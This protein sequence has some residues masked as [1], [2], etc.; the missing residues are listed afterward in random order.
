MK[1]IL[2]PIGVIHSPFTKLE[3]MPIQPTGSIG[4]QGTIEIFPEY[5]QALQDLEGFSHLYA[6]Y[7]FHMSKGWKAKVKP[8][9]DD[10][11]RGLFSTRAPKRPNPIGLSVLEIIAIRENC[12]TVNN[13]DILDKTPLLDIKPYIPQFEPVENLR[14]G[15]LSEQIDEVE[16]KRSD[17]RFK[18]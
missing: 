8:F 3:D 13:L 7:Q 4:T 9:L 6:I 14:I 16:H 12:I 1:I 2:N 15:W 11:E 5:S 10:Q 17:Q 18:N